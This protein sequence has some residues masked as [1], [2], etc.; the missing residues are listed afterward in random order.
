MYLVIILLLSVLLYTH[1]AL[2]QRELNYL[3]QFQ[4]NFNPQDVEQKRATKKAEFDIKSSDKDIN[5]FRN[6]FSWSQSQSNNANSWEIFLTSSK[7]SQY[8]SRKETEVLLKQRGYNDPKYENSFFEWSKKNGNS[9]DIASWENSQDF[10]VTTEFLN[11]RSVFNYEPDMFIYYW[12]WYTNHKND[13]V[14]NDVSAWRTASDDESYNYAK[15]RVNAHT[16][17]QN[18][19]IDKGIYT[20]NYITWK[21]KMGIN[22]FND[23]VM[24]YMS[25]YDYKLLSYKQEKRAEVHNYGYGDKKQFEEFWIWYTTTPNSGYNDP[26]NPPTVRPTLAPTFAPT[27]VSGLPSRLDAIRST[28]SNYNYQDVN[29]IKT[30]IENAGFKVFATPSYG[31]LTE[32]LRGESPITS[33]GKFDDAYF[34]SNSEI[35]VAKGFSKNINDYAWYG[36]A[37]YDGN[38][39]K[40]FGVM[41]FRGYQSGTSVKNFFYPVQNRPLYTYV[42]NADGTSIES[43]STDT[44]TYFSDNAGNGANGYYRTTGFSADDGI[45]GFSNGHSVNG[46]S[47]GPGLLRA[48]ASQSY[49][50]ENYH[51][52]DRGSTSQKLYWGTS[53]SS[54]Q[55]TLVVFTED[56]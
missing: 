1:G 22:N 11:K 14:T 12:R 41:L 7:Y 21:V 44:G 29:A 52:S 32:N 3:S 53:I 33:A 55:W 18:H 19:G 40:G 51:S 39:F 2:S 23:H 24:Q 42:L 47:P 35:D 49:G 28:M 45:W 36:F 30:T 46:D 20:R 25:S 43:D 34:R 26:T 6:F 8:R 37:A 31:A 15:D 13:G 48:H 17:L 56:K 4:S 10:E 5:L 50:V 38:N 16:F 27:P 9:H 54:T